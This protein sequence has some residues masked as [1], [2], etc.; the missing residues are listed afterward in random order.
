MNVDGMLNEVRMAAEPMNAAKIRSLARQLDALAKDMRAVARTKSQPVPARVNPDDMFNMLEDS[1]RLDPKEF[2]FRVQRDL[3][4]HLRYAV[5]AVIY[6][7]VHSMRELEEMMGYDPMKARNTV[8]WTRKHGYLTEPGRNGP[9][10]CGAPTRKA[11]SLL[12]DAM[13]GL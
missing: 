13:G 3:D 6:E 12:A 4:A 10:M 8:Q 5:T 7:S 11:L 2:G 9:V 1:W